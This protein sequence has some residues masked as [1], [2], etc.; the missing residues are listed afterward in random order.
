MTLQELHI[1]D[2]LVS[3]SEGDTWLFSLG[4]VCKMRFLELMVTGFL[5]Q[6]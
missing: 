1:L 6:T 5:Y 2:I 3:L 4:T